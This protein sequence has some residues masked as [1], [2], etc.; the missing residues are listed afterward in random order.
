MTSQ[1]E[2]KMWK[3]VLFE[4]SLFRDNDSIE[5]KRGQGLSVCP[6]VRRSVM[7]IQCLSRNKNERK[8]SLSFFLFVR[9]I[10]GENICVCL[11]LSFVAFD[12]T[13]KC[14]KC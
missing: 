1:L 12:H 14:S 11:S 8:K 2:L 13:Y 7:S 4:M 5:R 3:V 9:E 10:E 6:F